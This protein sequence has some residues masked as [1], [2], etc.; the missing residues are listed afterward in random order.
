MCCVLSAAWV[1]GQSR[2]QLFA[3][4]AAEHGVVRTSCREAAYPSVSVV[5]KALGL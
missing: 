1:A 4:L 5:N 3:H 2:N